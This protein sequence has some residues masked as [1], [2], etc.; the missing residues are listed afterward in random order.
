MVSASPISP[1]KE[2]DRK[3]GEKWTAAEPSRP[4]KWWYSTF[5]TVTAM[6]GA[7]V[8]SLPYAMAY[9]GWGPGTIM[10]VL[11]WGLTLNT[12]WQ[13]VQLHECVPGTRFDRYIDLGR[14]AFGPKLGPW[15]VL[16]QQLIVQVGCCI[17][18]MVTGGKCLK[19]F[20]DVTCSTCTPVRP[21]YWILAF[22]GV[23]F[24]LSQLPNFNSVA[25][26]SLAA[27][28]MS[29]SY[30]TIAWAGSIAHGR[31][32]DVSYGYKA[33]SPSE[34]TFRIFNALG[35]I[36]FAF[37]GHAVALEIQATMP[38]TPERPSKVPMWQGV[39]GAYFVNAICY[40]PVALICYWA[41]GQDVDD[42][43]LNNLQRPAWLIASANLMVVV[44]VIGSYQVFAMPV[45]DLLERMMVN[46][47]GFKH[48]VVLRFFT[49][50]IYVA[51]TL[52]IG[53]SFPFFGDL[54]GFFGGF[55]FAPTSF[56]LPSIM[57]L[58]IK[59]PKRFSITWLVNWIS[60][61]VGVF[62][63]L[64]STIGGLRNII[65]D[66]SAYRFYA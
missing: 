38:S 21:T 13:M 62:I 56:F 42:N 41:F 65:A 16:P 17:V 49:R 33:T 34:S 31:L 11:T 24:L 10:L 5:H 55:G 26:V 22:G 37:A 32:P 53:V 40:F 3:S 57:W 15:I 6:I 58:I 2:T 66:S 50:T 60:I 43:V 36:S 4:A 54:L 20:V 44:H 28:V 25:G 30:S 7:G 51:F 63:M 39:M 18:Y 27:A 8:L 47:F 59:K 1:S 52:F 23:H 64:A 19:Q 35:Q 29:L 14:Y 9:L 46:K 48:G 45:F 12:M 61:I